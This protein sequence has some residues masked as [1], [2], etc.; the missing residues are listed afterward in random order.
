[1]FKKDDNRWHE[2]ECCLNKTRFF[3][4]SPCY[5]TFRGSYDHS[6]YKACFRE[7]NRL[8]S[9]TRERSSNLKVELTVPLLTVTLVTAREPE[10][11]RTP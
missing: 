7:A 4:Q 3:K 8:I 9:R 6:I 11:G 1:M 2:K 10:D 5:R